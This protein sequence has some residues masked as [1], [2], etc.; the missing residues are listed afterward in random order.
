MKKSL[1]AMAVL[2][3]AGAAQAQSSVTMFGIVDIGYGQHKTTGVGGYSIKSGGI[4]D[5]SLIHI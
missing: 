3:A 2:A 5:L 4:M 1:I